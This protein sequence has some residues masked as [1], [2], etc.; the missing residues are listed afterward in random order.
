MVF[1][2]LSFLLWFFPFFIS[3][4]YL[5]PDKYKNLCLFGFSIFFYAY[6]TFETPFYILLILLFAIINYFLAILIEKKNKFCKFLL[7]AGLI[8]DLGSLFVFKYIDFI[9]ENLNIVFS[10][11][12]INFKLPQLDL[13]L[14]VGISFFTF[15]VISYLTD[16]YRETVRAERSLLRF[17]VYLLMF[18]KLTMGPITRYASI[19]ESLYLRSHTVKQFKDGLTDFVFGLGMKVLL[20]NRIGILWNDICTIGFESISVLYAWLGIIAYSMQIYFDFYGYSLMAVGLGKMLGFQLPQNFRYPYLSISMT[21]FWRRWHIT[22]GAWFREYIYIPLGGNRRG[23]ARTLFNLAIVWMSTAC[24]HGSGWNFI[25]WGIFLFAVITLEKAGIA[26]ILNKFPILGHA[27]MAL[28]IPISWLIFVTDSPKKLLIYLGRL[29][30]I[31]GISVYSLDYTAYSTAFYI[32]LAVGL[33]FCTRIPRA[34][35]DSIRRTVVIYPILAAI[36]GISVYFLY[37]GVN[38]P[39]MYFRF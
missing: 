3:V 29:V 39:F 16:V 11:F 18:P 37:K 23:K 33:L 30:G 31:G 1:S 4:Y 34:I 32:L 24:W 25:I 9:F 10:G 38:D 27:Y 2:S 36:F 22:L 6:G 21:E 26:K 35:F 19:H 7:A 12:H 28:M 14:P 20:A 8:I 5:S 15:Q 17:S 13:I